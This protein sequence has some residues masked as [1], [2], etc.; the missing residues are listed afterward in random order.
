MEF[1]TLLS[2]LLLVFII[3]FAR[4]YQAKLTNEDVKSRVFKASWVDILE[5]NLPLY[6]KLPPELKPKLEGLINLFLFD[7]VFSGYNGQ[8]ITD[9]I[10]V[11][12]A[13]QACM[14]MLNRDEELYPYLKNIYVY[15]SAF[16]S[17][18]LVNNGVV[19]TV[20]QSIRIGESWHLG[21][22]V[23]SWRH[24]K[25]G[26]CNDHDGKNVVYHEFAHQ[27]DHQ[28]GEIDGTPILDDT[29]N[30]K[31]WSKVFSQEYDQLRKKVRHHRKTFIDPYGAES[32]GEFFAVVTELFFEKPVLFLREHPKL[33]H[34]LKKYYHLNPAEWF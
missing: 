31:S 21:H 9:E 11:T 32:E 22:V 12:I 15:P 20:Q 30:Y 27:L 10:R 29:E 33:Y 23:L 1:L 7:K 6:K 28:D 13:A 5:Q 17:S 4:K 3:Y 25:Q 26:G 2:L 19:S 34:E 14:L 24:S 18:H 8:E 16:K